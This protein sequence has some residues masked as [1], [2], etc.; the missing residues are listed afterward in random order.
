MM[1]LFLRH[2]CTAMPPRSHWELKFAMTQ[3]NL[4]RIS[5]IILLTA[6]IDLLISAIFPDP[7][8]R[9]WLSTRS[10][11]FVAAMLLLLPL[12]VQAGVVLLRVSLRHQRVAFALPRA[13]Y[14]GGIVPLLLV[15]MAN[16][17]S[18]R[19]LGGL[20]YPALR[21]L[22]DG[23]LMPFVGVVLI[24]IWA[25]RFNHV[26]SGSNGSASGTLVR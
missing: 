12:I 18:R 10:T 8:V 6:F 17:L 16:M 14:D 26:F 25:I 21:G 2:G 23:M 13:S 15:F 22:A 4:A 3:H 7:A 19:D 24:A 11:Q 9:G 20:T 5:G 1:S